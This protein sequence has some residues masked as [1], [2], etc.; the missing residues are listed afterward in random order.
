MFYLQIRAAPPSVRKTKIHGDKGY[1]TALIT[2]K[3]ETNTQAQ[4]EIGD[5][6][7]HTA[8]ITIKHGTNT[9]AQTEIRSI[10]RSKRK[11]TTRFDTLTF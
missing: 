2:I 9:Q 10:L 7:Y 1:H 8:L 4:T 3:H 6:G 11:F 5:K